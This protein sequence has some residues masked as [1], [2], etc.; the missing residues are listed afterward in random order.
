MQEE[1][2]HNDRQRENRVFFFHSLAGKHDWED[3]RKDSSSFQAWAI[4]GLYIH[5]TLFGLLK[6]KS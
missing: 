5:Q 1:I 3:S 2:N 6:T 4:L